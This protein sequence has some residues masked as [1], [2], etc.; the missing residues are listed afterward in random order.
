MEPE[1][2]ELP[3]NLVADFTEGDILWPG[4]RALY[5]WWDNAR[6]ERA[7]PKRQDFSP[8]TMVP[9]LPAIVLHDVGGNART[10]TFRLVGTAVTEVLGFDPTGMGLDEIPST[11][12]MRTRYDWVL[13]HKKPY[14]CT[15][16]PTRWAKKD[17]K[18]YST[19]VLP[20]GP[21]DDEVT[22]LIA[23]LTFGKV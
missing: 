13:E 14:M 2:D 22:M 11:A 7:F 19:L 6:G 1:T 5:A 20:L 16:L 4:G 21:S 3:K 15:N 17:Y 10:Y 8:L 23:S 12:T 18:S 9:F